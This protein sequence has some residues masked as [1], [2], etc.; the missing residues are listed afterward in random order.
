MCTTTTIPPVFKL[1]CCV[2]AYS[3]RS[4]SFPVLSSFYGM[5]NGPK[6]NASDMIKIMQDFESKKKLYYCVV[7]KYETPHQGTIK[8]HV[9]MKHM[10][11]VVTL[12]CLQC[13]KSFKLKQVLKKHYM[14]IHGLLEPAAKAMLPA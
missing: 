8:R 14:D 4:A 10:P 2:A 6:L 7:C 3:L 9:E 5:E 11:Q 1:R 12:N 13:P